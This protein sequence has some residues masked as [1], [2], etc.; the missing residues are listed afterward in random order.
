MALEGSIKDF[1]LADILQLI[2][3][4]RKTGILSLQ[5]RSFNATVAF[6]EGRVIW[7]L[8]RSGEELLDRVGTLL[9]RSGLLTDLQLKRA[10]EQ[11]HQTDAKIANVIM[12]LNL[13]TKEEISATLRI[14]IADTVYGLF[15]LREGNY[16]FQVCEVGYDPNFF[17]PISTEHLLMEGMRRIDEW[18]AILR[19][20]KGP[21][22]VLGRTEKPLPE[23][24]GEEAPK[25]SPGS[26]S[27][28]DLV[29]SSQEENESGGSFSGQQRILELVD[30]RRTVSDLIPISRL[31]EFDTYR[32]CSE[33]V[34]SGHLAILEVSVAATKS[35][36]TEPGG[37]GFPPIWMAMIRQPKFY[38]T[39]AYAV[40][41]FALAVGFANVLRGRLDSNHV[42]WGFPDPS[43][44]YGQELLELYRYREG[45]LP[46]APVD[47]VRELAGP[48]AKPIKSVTIPELGL[49]KETAP[50]P[51]HHATSDD[52][53]TG[54]EA[55]KSGFP[56]DG[57]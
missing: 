35:L 56:I 47:L 5:D 44:R 7:A 41:V 53:K 8:T 34:K 24:E 49:L 4:Q 55:D 15:R 17:E 32:I 13:A 46:E 39:V 57:Q 52:Q 37:L 18:P 45:R 2:Q 26:D 31:G 43:P 38:G 9:H 48:G 21:G 11:A 54:E 19:T 50:I 29:G 22:V 3:I 25:M 23:T 1:G 20:I 27:F 33:L 42:E 14:E 40:L 28:G 51:L 12:E 6:D 36:K 30:G 16:S 10:T